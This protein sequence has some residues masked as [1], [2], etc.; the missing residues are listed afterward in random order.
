MK[1]YIPYHGSHAGFWIYEGYKKAWESLGYDVE[2]L[3]TEGDYTKDRPKEYQVMLTEAP[4]YNKVKG[5]FEFIEDAQR[6]YVFSQPNSFPGKWGNHPNFISLSDDTIINR[7]NSIDHVKLWS[8]SNTKDNPYFH[9]W[10]H[11]N[12]VPLAFDD[13]TYSEL[14]D[15]DYEFDVC[16]VGGLAN[17]G[18][19]EKAEIMETYFGEL[20]KLKLKF[21]IFI[22]DNL[23]LE[24]ESKLLYNSKI[25]LN[26]HDKY[27]QVLGLDSNER[28]FKSLGLNGFLISDNV[29]EVSNLFPTV[30]IANNPKE[31]SNLVEEYLSILGLES[32]KESNRSIIKEQHTYKNRVKQ[33]LSL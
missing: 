32:Y 15:K 14:E 8:F 11:V 13:E 5:S 18:F 9:K 16:Y 19:N 28:T 27:Q 26:L 10:K 17:N 25:S 24:Q 3:T 12:Y 21:G 6:A 31:M 22:N 4:L 2:Y 30:P 23:S 33:L 20:S 29:A 1:I 7:L